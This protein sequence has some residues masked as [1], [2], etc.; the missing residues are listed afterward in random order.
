MLLVE[1]RE[2][3][4]DQ[5][6]SLFEEIG[7]GVIAVSNSDDAIKQIWSSP[8]IGAVYTDI[9]LDPEQDFDI[10]GVNLMQYLRKTR[11]GLPVIGY[12]GRFASGEL[13][14]RITDQFD[15]W[16]P[17]GA[18]TAEQMENALL[19]V[20]Q[21][22]LQYTQERRA[23]ADARLRTLQEKY[24]IDR[25]LLDEYLGLL[26]NRR[27]EVEQVLA[28]SGYEALVVHGGADAESRLIDIRGARR[29]GT[30]NVPIVLWVRFGDDEVEV[31]V[32]GFPQLY[33]AAE[34]EDLA[35]AQVI[36]LMLLYA[37]D[38][39]GDDPVGG[40]AAELRQ[41]LQRAVSLS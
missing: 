38:L 33:A 35:L 37:L 6:R 18:L 16:Y 36:D 1:D 39:E 31:E 21:R 28:A 4:L 12:S 14:G 24:S 23:E 10:S 22:A 11:P 13:D 40:V 26:P 20:Q 8:L 29:Y 19:D 5:K 17:R 25:S 41:F 7:C 34:T 32:L 3:T 15:A 27:Y 30:L 2:E 9:D